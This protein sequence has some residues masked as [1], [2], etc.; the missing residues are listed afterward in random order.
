[1]TT[2]FELHWQDTFLFLSYLAPNTDRHTFQIFPEAGGRAEQII[3]QRLMDAWPEIEEANRKGCTVS[4]TVNELREGHSRSGTNVRRIRAVWLDDDGDA[5]PVSAFPI[6]PS[7]TVETSPG[8]Y[9]HY[10]LVAG[11]WM[12]DE[13]SKQGFADVMRSIVDTFGGDSQATDISRVLRLPGTWN[14][15][16]KLAEPYRAKLLP[17]E[18]DPVR[19]TRAELLAAFCADQPDPANKAEASGQVGWDN[20]HQ[21]MDTARVESALKVIPAEGREEWLTVGMALHHATYGG[22]DGY[23]LWCEWSLTTTLGNYNPIDQRR[24]WQS[25]RDHPNPKTLASVFALARELGWTEHC[26]STTNAIPSAAPITSGA[27][28]EETMTSLR[29]FSLSSNDFRPSPA[30]WKGLADLASA[31]EGLANGTAEKLVF[32]SSLDP[33]VGKTQTVIRFTKALL[34]SADHPHV[35]VLICVGRLEEIRSYVESADLG[36]DE[37]AVLVADDPKN[38]SLNRLGNRDRSKARVLFT[39]QQMLEARAKRYGSF[40]AIAEF[41][42]GGE[43]RQVRIWDEAC[44][45]ARPLTVDVSLIEGMTNEI[46]NQSGKLHKTLKDLIRAIDDTADGRF[47]DV[48][49]LE[50]TEID[51]G[52]AVGMLREV[53][54]PVQSAM[55][56][57]YLLSGKTVAVIKH[58]NNN[59]FVH[60]EN[61]LPDDLKPYVVCDASGRVRQTYPHWAAGRGDLVELQRAEKDYRDLT[62][63][64][65]ETA[66]SKSAWR[67]NSD[68]LIQG[69]AATV[70]A[71]PDRRFLT[72]HHM[73][74]KSLPV[75]VPAEISRK[76]LNPDRLEFVYWGS[77]DCRATNRFRD[78][79]RVILAGT[80]FMDESHYEAMARLSRGVPSDRQLEREHRRQ[81]KLGEHADLILQ[82]VCRGSVRKLVDGKCGECHV[83]IIAA[84]GSGIGGLLRDGIIF[85]GATIQPWNPVETSKQPSETTKAAMTYVA[86]FFRFQPDGSL[87]VADLRGRLGVRDKDNF[88]KRVINDPEFLDLLEARGLAL[89]KARGRAGSRITS[90]SNAEFEE[91]IEKE[92]AF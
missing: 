78:I 4:V 72:V 21:P 33:G 45:P 50:A 91:F 30:Q 11:D 75:D 42:F 38:E 54:K 63:F 29:K 73:E 46:K 1:M 34:T 31:L 25:F 88:N 64:L 87:S 80:L 70:D 85:P 86:D 58:G 84:A 43:P 92:Y 16:A 28:S 62:V 68:T 48:P 36:D 66:G 44:L 41:W 19:Y 37:Y 90:K 71:E 76:A 9:H 79:D 89:V 3:D 83:Y 15:K 14:H 81:I 2:R 49:D 10:W 7:L 23:D 40:A 59:A 74:S 17:V 67:M 18:G 65:W 5:K 6:P 35:G 56:D 32:L 60:Y 12:A 20:E 27:L 8:R 24:Q 57:L 13:Q 26:M 61:T 53:K 69:I 55:R 39:T 47:V 22:D 82:A 77:E 52:A 51:V